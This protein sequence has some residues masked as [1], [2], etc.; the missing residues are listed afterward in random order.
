MLHYPT[1]AMTYNININVPYTMLQYNTNTNIEYSTQI[2][3]YTTCCILPC[4]I[5]ATSNTNIYYNIPCKVV[6]FTNPLFSSQAATL[7]SAKHFCWTLTTMCQYLYHTTINQCVQSTGKYFSIKLS[8]WTKLPTTKPNTIEPN[9]TK[10]NS[11]GLNSSVLIF[12]HTIPTTKLSSIG[13]NYTPL[14]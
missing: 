5:N 7:S 2:Y 3:T 11:T 6:R 4:N 8:Y 14:N 12:Y 13:L 1:T 9:T 10:L